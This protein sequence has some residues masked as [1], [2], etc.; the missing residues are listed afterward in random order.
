M[1]EQMNDVQKAAAHVQAKIQSLS[2][3]YADAS[4]YAQARALIR[5]VVNAFN[6]YELNKLVSARKL[7][8]ESESAAKLM[9]G[10]VQDAMDEVDYTAQLMAHL[11]DGNDVNNAKFLYQ[12]VP[13]ELKTQSRLFVAVWTAVKHLANARYGEALALLR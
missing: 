13:D 9:V 5:D 2:A 12:R 7:D 1:A 10:F 4:K 11:I 6:N 8:S 3:V